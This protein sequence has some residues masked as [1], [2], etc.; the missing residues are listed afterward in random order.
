MV[1]QGADAVASNV[2]SWRSTVNSAIEGGREAVAKGRDTV[3]YAVDQGRE[4]Y[5]QAKANPA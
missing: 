1:A 5:Q 4:A 3:N 2:D